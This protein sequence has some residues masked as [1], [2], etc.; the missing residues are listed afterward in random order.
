MRL[1]FTRDSHLRRFNRLLSNNLAQELEMLKYVPALRVSTDVE[2]L[3]TG[4]YATECTDRERA[5]Q[6]ARM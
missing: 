4:N 2:N 3:Q 6:K 1:K 5:S